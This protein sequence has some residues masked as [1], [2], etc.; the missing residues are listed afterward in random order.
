M[1]AARGMTVLYLKRIAEGPLRLGELPLGQTRRLT[2]PEVRA[3]VQTE[4][5]GEA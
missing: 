4:K 3:L 5:G 2:E 1:M